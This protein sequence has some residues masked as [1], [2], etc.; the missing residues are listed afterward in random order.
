MDEET[1]QKLK[2]KFEISYMMVKENIAFKKMRPLCNMEECHRIEIGAS[3]R[4]DHGCASFV[5][6]LLLLTLKKI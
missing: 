4:N 3:Y 5:D 6:S 1:R 2:R